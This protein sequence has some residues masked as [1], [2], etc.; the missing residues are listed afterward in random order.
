ML[1]K[2][3]IKELQADTF[4]F[5]VGSVSAKISKLKNELADVE[6]YARA[7]NFTDP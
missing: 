2:R 7:A 6:S 1:I 4:G 3:I 5:T